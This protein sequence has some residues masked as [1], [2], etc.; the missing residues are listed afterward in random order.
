MNDAEKPKRT[1]AATAARMRAREE[2]AADLLVSRGWE[3]N[4][5]DGEDWGEIR[6]RQARE[7]G[8][9]EAMTDAEYVAWRDARSTT[10]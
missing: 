8:A 7:A 1:A 6:L 9:P 10:P 4:T 3:V 2:K 5:P